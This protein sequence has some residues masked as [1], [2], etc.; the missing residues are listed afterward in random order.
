MVQDIST[1][2]STADYKVTCVLLAN[3]FDVHLERSMS[4][5]QIMKRI[6]L[7]TCMS[8]LKVG[9]EYSES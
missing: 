3:D 9:F 4:L 8:H 1:Q 6:N 5:D 2:R 7:R